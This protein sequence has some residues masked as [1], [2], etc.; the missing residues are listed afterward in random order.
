MKRIGFWVSAA[1]LVAGFYAAVPCALGQ[2]KDEKQIRALED[3]YVTAVKAR[4]LDGIMKAYAPG[5]ELVVF[6]VIPP[7]Q[8]NGFDAYKKDWGEDF[9]AYPGPGWQFELSDLSIT[10][11]GKLGYGHSIQHFV[12]TTKEGTKVDLTLRVTDCYRKIGGKWLIAHEHVS[13]PVDLETGKP[14]MTSKP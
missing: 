9:T 10:T 5:A 11:D 13:V 4:D 1:L 6:D 8:Y 14:D 12:G 3:R 2:T 7:R